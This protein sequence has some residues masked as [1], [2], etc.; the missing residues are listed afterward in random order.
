M[1]KSEAKPTQKK[2]TTRFTPRQ[3]RFAMLYYL[4]NSPSYGNALQSAKDAGFSEDYAKNITFEKER[5]NL[6][7][8]EDIIQEITGKPPTKKKLV[9]K[10]KKVLEESLESTDAKIKQDT[11]K[12]IMNTDKE[13]SSKQDLTTNGESIN[14]PVAL[15]EFVD[16]QGEDTDTD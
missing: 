14:S 12:F 7:W 15:V 1:T 3:I 10:S 4:P 5:A 2:K 8:M 13:F 6:K 16:G 9:E 11:A